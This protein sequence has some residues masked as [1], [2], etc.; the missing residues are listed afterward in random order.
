VASTTPTT[1]A[2]SSSG[3]KSPECAWLEYRP[4][5][6][7]HQPIVSSHTY[8]RAIC[9]NPSCWNADVAPQAASLPPMADEF[10]E[11]DC[12]TSFINSFMEWAD[13]IG[14]SYLAWNWEVPRFSGTDYLRDVD[15]TDNGGTNLMLLSNWD[16]AALIT[17]VRAFEM[18]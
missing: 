7:D 15:H 14:I 16:G 8:D 1:R 4:V 5:D 13:S 9:A 10:G 11:T 18:P 12:S 6:P 3:G 17:N 2:A